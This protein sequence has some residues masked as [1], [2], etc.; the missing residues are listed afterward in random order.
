MKTSSIKRITDLV[1]E[2]KCKFISLK[3]LGNDGALQQLDIPSSQLLLE[4]E[5]KNNYSEFEVLDQHVFLDPFRS[6]PTLTAF[7]YHH[8]SSVAK[9]RDLQDLEGAVADISFWV[10]EHHAE[11][12]VAKKNQV[13]PFDIYSNFRADIALILEQIGIKVISHYH[14]KTRGELII[15]IS[16]KGLLKL[17]DDVVVT[18]FIINNC[19]ISY[20]LK[21]T[22][23]KKEETNLFIRCDVNGVKKLQVDSCL[24]LYQKVVS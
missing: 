1:A 10:M 20:N 8:S 24:S 5:F 17:A 16:S 14:G 13:D 19:S 6:L 9:L 21:I 15:K 12:Y 4:E 11:G 2:N 23:T 7:C 22:L 18:R 3:Y